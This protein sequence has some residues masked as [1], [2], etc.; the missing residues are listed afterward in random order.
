MDKKGKRKIQRSDTE[1]RERW[2]GQKY[3]T[4][5]SYS[6]EEIKD[7]SST[8][9]SRNP[10]IWV[11]VLACDDL[12]SPDFNIRDTLRNVINVKKEPSFIVVGIK[13]CPRLEG[14]VRSRIL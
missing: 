12:K 10:S 6:Y 7:D 11:W 14:S 9:A 4:I 3:R 1:Q 8:F 2:Q 13:I 5:E